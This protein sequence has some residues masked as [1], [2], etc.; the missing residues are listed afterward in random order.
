MQW[1]SI[2]K[3]MSSPE[4]LC[5]MMY[6]QGYAGMCWEFCIVMSTIS[7]SVSAV[8]F[9]P[10]KSS[11]YVKCD[12]FFYSFFFLLP[13]SPS[14]SSLFVICRTIKPFFEISHKFKFNYET[15]RDFEYDII[16]CECKKHHFFASFC[17][18]FIIYRIH[19]SNRILDVNF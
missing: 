7:T 4:R 13:F 15:M 8:L 3:H 17:K 2:P 9:K 11:Q 16:P 18:Y 14:F 12:L 19:R 1:I 5:A 6:S 10:R